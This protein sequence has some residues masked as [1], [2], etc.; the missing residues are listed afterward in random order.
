MLTQGE[1]FEDE[2]LAGTEGT[3]HPAKQMPEPHDHGKNSIEARQR[4]DRQ[5]LDIVGV[6]CFDDPQVESRIGQY[7]ADVS[8]RESGKPYTHS[9]IPRPEATQHG[10]G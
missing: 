1:V 9:T 8:I 5:L 6:R 2:V 10:V 7:P 4:S 3:D